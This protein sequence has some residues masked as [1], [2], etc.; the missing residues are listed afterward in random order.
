MHPLQYRRQFLLGPRP[1]DGL[2]EAWQRLSVAG[3]RTLQAHLDLAV[4]QRTRNGV[5]LTLLGYL[6]DP[7]HPD[8]DDDGVLDDLLGRVERAADVLTETDSL[9][10]RWALVATDA[11]TALLLHD[12]NGLRQVVH[13][14]DGGV[15]AASDTP[16]LGHALRLEDDAE[17]VERFVESPYF[18]RSDTAWWP[19]DRTRCAGVRQLL[20]NHVLDLGSGA[21]RRFWPS[22]PL[23]PRTLESGVERGTAILQGMMAGAARRAPLTVA[24]TAGVDSRILL[25]GARDVAGEVSFY[26]YVHHQI[27]RNHADV[28]IPQRLFRRLGLSHRVID[29]I[30]PEAFATSDDPDLAEYRSVYLSNTAVPHP[31]WGAISYTMSQEVPDDHILVKSNCNAGTKNSHGWAVHERGG[32]G[33]RPGVPLAGF[34]GMRGNEFAVQEFGRW[35]ASAQSVAPL[36]YDFYDL[37]YCEQRMGRW[38]AADWLERDLDHETFDPANS[39]EY[40]AALLGVPG[41]HRRPPRRLY[42]EMVRATWPE[43]LQVPINPVRLRDRLWKKARP[44]FVATGS[45]DVIKRVVRGPR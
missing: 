30:T 4:T 23:E 43:L 1:A 31:V 17:A 38:Q 7:R 32:D 10:G 29:C 2:P 36:G 37:F 45:L 14:Q 25:G 24:V 13:A 8:R 21:V 39:R 35:A 16:L 20:P 15:W 5:E 41:E 28:A 9:G 33:G 42:R 34:M 12:A 26:T 11:D 19:G 6:I 40:C 27:D 44:A 18:Q 3:E 22:A